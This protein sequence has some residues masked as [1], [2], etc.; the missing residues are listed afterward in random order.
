M[1]AA[2]LQQPRP[3]Q[4]RT[5]CRGPTKPPPSRALL[6]MPSRGRSLPSPVELPHALGRC[7][8]VGEADPELLVDDDDLALSDQAAVH[9]E[10][11]RLAGESFELDDRALSELEYLADRNL[12]APQLDGELHRNVEDEVDVVP[13]A[14]CARLRRELLEDLRRLDLHPGSRRA[15]CIHGGARRARLADRF[16]DVVVKHGE[17]QGPFRWMFS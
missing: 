16:R 13:G 6:N 17:L 12:G 15:W 9:E 3:S 10:V 14:H 7:D 1:P 4:R 2:Q 11:E 5:R 8:D